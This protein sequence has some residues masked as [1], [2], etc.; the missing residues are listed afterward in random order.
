[1]QSIRFEIRETTASEDVILFAGRNKSSQ[2]QAIRIAKDLA[3][4][5]KET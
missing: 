5:L 3:R 4:N 2:E 1:M